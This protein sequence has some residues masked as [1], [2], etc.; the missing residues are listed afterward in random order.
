MPAAASGTLLSSNLHG[1]IPALD[2][3]RGLAILMV[4]MDH[5][6]GEMPPANSLERAIV[7]VTGYGSYGVDLFFVLSGFLITGILYDTRDKAFYFRNFYMRRFLRIFPL[8]YGVLALLSFFVG[9]LIP[10]LQGTIG[11]PAGASGLGLAL[12]RKYLHRH[13]R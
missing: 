10:L 12:W 9:P 1:H 4:L 11:L 2:G 6:I 8:Y 3:V 7:Y 5:F 13:P